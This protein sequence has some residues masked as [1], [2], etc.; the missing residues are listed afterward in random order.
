MVYIFQ[1]SNIID[2]TART[3]IENVSIQ[4][5]IHNGDCYEALKGSDNMTKHRKEIE[6]ICRMRDDYGIVTGQ[7]SVLQKEEYDFYIPSLNLCIEYDGQQHFKY[8]DAFKIPYEKF[9]EQ[10]KIDKLKTE[11]CKN[12]KINLLRIKYK[13]TNKKL[14]TF[15]NDFLNGNSN[16]TNKD[17]IFY[18]DFENSSYF[19]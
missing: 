18:N 19:N 1:T 16:I 17:I 2:I 14:A 13:L 11:Y 15:L 8:E 7:L 9:V 5:A 6:T 12:K 4:E 10:Q 3:A